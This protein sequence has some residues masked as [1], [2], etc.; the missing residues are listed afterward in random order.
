MLN[1]KV[2]VSAFN[3]EEALVGA[4]STAILREGAEHRLGHH[5]TSPSP[6][7]TTLNLVCLMANFRYQN[8]NLSSTESKMSFHCVCTPIV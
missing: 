6:P 8:L 2:Q 5:H 4:P 1:V 3:K 7:P